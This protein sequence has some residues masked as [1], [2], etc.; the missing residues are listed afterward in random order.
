MKIRKL[1]PL[2]ALLMA[3]AATAG[4]VNVNSA[5]AETL[6]RELDRIG[7]A[8]AEAIV[9]Y[10]QAHGPFTS[11]DALLEVRGIG[12]RVLEANRDNILLSDGDS[13]AAK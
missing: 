9:A 12:V 13:P 1:L 7:L 8:R 10:R 6:A 5:D 11:V 4:P 3:G 2:A